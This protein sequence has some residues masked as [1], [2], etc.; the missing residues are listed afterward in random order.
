MEIKMQFLMYLFTNEEA[1]LMANIYLL[2][3]L[4]KYTI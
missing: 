1:I 3:L 2:E 4:F